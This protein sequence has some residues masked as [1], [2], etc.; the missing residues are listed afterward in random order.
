MRYRYYACDVFTQTRF[1]G[2][3]LAVLPEAEGLSDEQMQQITREFNYSET[4]FVF[5]PEAGHTRKVRIFTPAQEIPFAGHPNVGTA[6]VLAATG[7]LGDIRS[8]TG[9]TF[10]EKAGLVPITIRTADGHIES[11]ELRAPQSISFGQTVPAH[12]IATALLL[13]EQDIFT[14]AHEPQVV[15]VGLPFVLAELKNRSALE[16]CRVNMKGFTDL[17]DVLKEGVRSSLYLYT[18]ATGDLD[19]RARMFA[20]LSG[21]PEDPATGSASCAVAGLLARQCKEESGMFTYRVAQGVEM[22]RPSALLARAEKVNGV[23]TSTWVGGS[24][25][26]VSEGFIQV[27]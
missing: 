4:T 5:A 25:V 8:L 2:N 9:V 13:P 16:R 26:M 14:T 21:V 18:R 23:V 15:S 22:G 10:E 3:P 12:Q 1:G 19:V 27:D 17:L 7:E 11:C 20:P 6:F 24:C